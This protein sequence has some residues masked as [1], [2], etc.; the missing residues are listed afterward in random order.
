VLYEHTQ[1]GLFTNR[2]ESG[3][4][5]GCLIVM[6]EDMMKFK[7]AKLLL[8]LPYLLA[9]CRHAGVMTIQLP[10]DLIDDELSVPTD[11]ESLD[12]E[13]SDNAHAID[14]GLIFYHIVGCAEM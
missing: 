5:V 6:V 9:V 12:P 10:Q 13:L 4:G 7:V 2:P 1:Q 8:E 3:E 11:V 14:E